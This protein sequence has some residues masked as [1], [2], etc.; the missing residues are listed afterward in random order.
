MFFLDDDSIDRG[1]NTLVW[2]KFEL[3]N[4]GDDDIDAINFLLIKHFVK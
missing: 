2:T 4:S 1:K 3:N